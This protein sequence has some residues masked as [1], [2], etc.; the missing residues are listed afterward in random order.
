MACRA[1]PQLYDLTCPLSALGVWRGLW[2]IGEAPPLESVGV[3]CGCR[4]LYSVPFSVRW[5]CW[6]R[7]L[8]GA[9]ELEGGW[10][11]DPGAATCRSAAEVA[12]GPQHWCWAVALERGFLLTAWPA[13]ALRRTKEQSSCGKGCVVRLLQVPLPPVASSF[14][15][16]R[17]F[18]HLQDGDTASSRFL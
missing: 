11:E 4:R 14:L 6:H 9:S 5:Q 10:I 16:Q 7:L 13:G 12:G 8:Q 1:C 18:P 17:L 15:L 3:S 2:W